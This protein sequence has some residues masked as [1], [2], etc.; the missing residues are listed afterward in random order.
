MRRLWTLIL[1]GLAVITVT[2]WITSHFYGLAVWFAPS[3][4]WMFA[5]F[6]EHGLLGA[7]TVSEPHA[8]EMP[9]GAN[10]DELADT[11]DYLVVERDI[12]VAVPPFGIQRG[13]GFDSEVAVW[14]PYWAL[15][16]ILLL[17]VLVRRR[18]HH[19]RRVPPPGSP[20]P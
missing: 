12:G 10:S 15:L 14:A 6:T 17:T 19:R 9:F 4:D 2:L 11:G 5:V 13:Q 8:A 1:S 7:V 16:I 18:V 3:N 20:A